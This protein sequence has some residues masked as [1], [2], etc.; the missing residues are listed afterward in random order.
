MATMA[1]DHFKREQPVLNDLELSFPNFT[2]KALSW[3]HNSDDPP[4]FLAHSPAGTFGLEFREWLNGQQMGVAQRHDDRRE[5][6]MEVIGTG[7]ENEYQP[8]NI[9]CASIKP[10]WGQKIKQADEAGLRQE[11]YECTTEVDEAWFI[12]PERMGRTYHQMEFPAYPLM[13]VYFRA[14]RYLGGSPHGSTWMQAEEDGGAYDPNVSSQTLEEALEDKLVKFSKPDRQAKL[15]T[16]HLVEH[17]LLIHGGWNA[18]KSN[19]PRHP[20]TL[21][22]IAERGAEFY[23][24]HPQR[25]LFDGVWFFNSLDSADD[26]N[27]LIGLPCGT[28]RVRWLAQLWPIPVRVYEGSAE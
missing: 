17:Y 20:L 26:V 25:E 1:S 18:Y 6:L 28:G 12:N 27:A 9:V 7:C 23:A 5:H 11:F 22:Q 15:A 2:G 19:T 13:T 21:R 16:H 10:R 4:D 8:K 14:I 3:V 24:A